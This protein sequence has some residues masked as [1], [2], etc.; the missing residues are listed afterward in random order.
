MQ[1]KSVLSCVCLAA[2]LQASAVYPIE[3]RDTGNGGG[4]MDYET[5]EDGTP[6]LNED[7]SITLRSNENSVNGMWFRTKKLTSPCP[8]EYT[9]FAFDY[10][11]NRV[12]SD[13]VLFPQE[14][15]GNWAQ[16]QKGSAAYTVAENYQTLYIVWD[17][18]NSPAAPWGSEEKYAGSYYW[19]STNDA[20]GK[21]PGW[22]LTI[23]NLRMLT[24]EEA[25]TECKSQ[26]MTGDIADLLYAPNLDLM[27]DY[28]A[29]M[30]SNI[31]MRNEGVPN[32][33]L[34][35][36]NIIKPLPEAATTF[37]FDYKLLGPSFAPQIW[38]TAT[39][40]G[41]I[42]ELEGTPE[43]T[44]VEAMY[45]MPWKT[46]TFDFADKIKETGW[47][48][49]FGANDFIQVQFLDMTTDHMLWI[50]N[51]RWVF[52]KGG[53]QSA[54][55]DI[56]IVPERPADNRIFNLMGVECKAPLAP[57]IYI[58]NGKKFIVK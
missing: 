27:A 14:G 49:K 43:G 25:A 15:Y 40:L 54:I 12:V 30:E 36:S 4:N 19:V 29:A 48:Q 7:G 26:E 58:Q 38:L 20:N 5:N 18:V 42:V 55:D 33:L 13:V 31:Y 56:E 16:I 22:E 35:S 21:D 34:W 39:P 41:K 24:L 57:G 11:S 1:L 3:F 37:A 50:K 51:P 46:A 23:K 6:K 47:A 32:P 52:S 8:K 17:R 44:E 53:D 10:K 2:T 45:E 28:D 9:V